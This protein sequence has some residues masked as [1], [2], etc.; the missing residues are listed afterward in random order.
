MPVKEAGIL[1]EPAASLPIPK[2][3]HLELINA[4]S[5]PE[6]PPAVRVKSQGFLVFPYILLP[7]S[8]AKQHYGILLLANGI[9]PF[10]LNISVYRQS[11]S[12]GS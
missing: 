9:T 1:S 8:S 5:P 4:A 6:L 11:V 3:E 12:C 7:D 2:T 10:F